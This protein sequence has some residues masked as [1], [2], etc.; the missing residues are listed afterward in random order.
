MRGCTIR[1]D[2]GPARN[3]I[4]VRDLDKPNSMRYGEAKRQAHDEMSK[5][6]LLNGPLT[7]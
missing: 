4:A 5:I 2:N 7:V 1:P 6:D 3:A